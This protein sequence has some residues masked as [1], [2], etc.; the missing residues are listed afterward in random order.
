MR[1]MWAGAQRSWQLGTAAELLS[2]LNSGCAAM[3]R[4]TGGVGAQSA[5]RI[6]LDYLWLEP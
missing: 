5:C 1:I 4:V 2:F 3:P 6:W